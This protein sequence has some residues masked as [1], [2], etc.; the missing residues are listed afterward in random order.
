MILAILTQKVTSHI[1]HIILRLALFRHIGNSI[2]KINLQI[3]ILELDAKENRCLVLDERLG[4]TLT[5]SSSY[6]GHRLEIDGIPPIAAEAL[7]EYIYKD[8]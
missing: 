6:S 2:D 4:V 5:L 8:K 7:L 3:Y 1:H